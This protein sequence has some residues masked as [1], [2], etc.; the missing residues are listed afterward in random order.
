[1]QSS[2][3]S[4][5]TVYDDKAKTYVQLSLVKQK[6]LIEDKLETVQ[7]ATARA[8]KVVINSPKKPTPQKAAVTASKRHAVSA[9]KFK[10]PGKF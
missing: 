8:A 5:T 2:S 4:R 9:I 3:R 10:H 7:K 1:M 6:L